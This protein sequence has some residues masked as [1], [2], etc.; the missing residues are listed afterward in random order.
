MEKKQGQIEANTRVAPEK[1]DAENSIKVSKSVD[2]LTGGFTSLP[3]AD[4]ADDDT[5]R[6]KLVLTFFLKLLHTRDSAKE[7]LKAQGLEALS[8]LATFVS[9]ASFSISTGTQ[10]INAEELDITPTNLAMH[11]FNAASAGAAIKIIHDL[12]KQ[13]GFKDDEFRELLLYFAEFE[14][15]QKH[16]GQDDAI[17]RLIYRMQ[18]G[19]VS[20]EGLPEKISHKEWE[21]ERAELRNWAKVLDVPQQKLTLWERTQKVGAW[22]QSFNKNNDKKEIK[23]SDSVLNARKHLDEHK[24][25]RP[26]GFIKSALEKI[27][28]SA[29]FAKAVG[30]E[31][32]DSLKNIHSET[33]PNIK[34][35]W[36]AKKKLKTYLQKRNKRSRIMRKILAHDG[37]SALDI[38]Y[39]GS[40]I[41]LS[42]DFV[43]Q[44]QQE[45][46]RVEQHIEQ[47]K[48][49]RSSYNVAFWFNLSLVALTS[50]KAGQTLLGSMT[51]RVS[52]TKYMETGIFLFSTSAGIGPLSTIGRELK[53]EVDMLSSKRS[54]I[55]N[56]VKDHLE[57]LSEI[58]P[59]FEEDTPIPAEEHSQPETHI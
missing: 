45:N 6:K 20:F 10:L 53:E 42:S 57:R 18:R 25:E 58:E 51:G 12:M 29:K 52:P 50:W 49:L 32:I 8:D 38:E 40:A 14:H 22:L 54:Q 48:M 37:G 27:S 19:N 59:D 33:M 35:G 11:G 17:D 39:N 23:I 9:L 28:I 47:A 13:K 4:I 56:R 31:Y 46:K 2:E 24:H 21:V 44:I 5:N 43:T 16:Y 7:L 55:A 34:E 3:I 30:A 15:L 26:Q 41:R 1:Q 36:K